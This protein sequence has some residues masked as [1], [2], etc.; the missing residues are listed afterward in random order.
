MEPESFSDFI[1][2]LPAPIFDFQQIFY[3]NV[4]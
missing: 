3:T 4:N 2:A 1:S